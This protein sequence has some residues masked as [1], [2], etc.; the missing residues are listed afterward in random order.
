MF[1]EHLLSAVYV[2]LCRQT[3][4]EPGVDGAAREPSTVHMEQSQALLVGPPAAACT[5]D[6]RLC[7]LHGK[8]S[9]KAPV[10]GAQL[11]PS[12]ELHDS[13]K[14]KVGL[15]INIQGAGFTLD[16]DLAQIMTRKVRAPC[17]ERPSRAHGWFTLLTDRPGIHCNVP[18]VGYIQCKEI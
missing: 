12:A 4:R 2:H 11:T 9:S 5:L 14:S 6:R 15:F 18:Y 7:R 13:S 3:S 17:R 8:W 1:I 16:A 10:G